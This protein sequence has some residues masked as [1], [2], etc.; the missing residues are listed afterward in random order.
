MY[1]S[2]DATLT[3]AN[4][5]SALVSLS[6]DDLRYVLGG[7]SDSRKH[8]ITDFMMEHYSPTW[9]WIA[10][11][12][13][14]KENGKAIEKMKKYFKGKLGMLMII[15]GVHEFPCSLTLNLCLGKH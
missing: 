13:F 10:G 12:C 3:S 1:I 14:Y 8:R 11:R 6:D 7:S 5:H 15:H 2:T 4:L 9:E